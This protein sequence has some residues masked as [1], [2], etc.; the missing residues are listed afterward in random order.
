MTYFEFL[1]NRFRNLTLDTQ[2]EY[3]LEKEGEQQAAHQWVLTIR[4]F[5]KYMNFL[6]LPVKYLLQKTGIVKSDLDYNTRYAEI[7]AYT[8]RTLAEAKAAQRAGQP[9]PVNQD[10]ATLAVVPPVQES[11]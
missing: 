6:I 3:T 9:V 4:K 11:N 7:K 2:I 10:A 1:D 5:N 8:E